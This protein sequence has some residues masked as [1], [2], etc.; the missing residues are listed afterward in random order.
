MI[1]AVL[2]AAL[3]APQIREIE[4]SVRRSM[5]ERQIP[6]VVIRVD[7]GGKNVYSKA[8]GYRDVADRVPANVE[9]R[10]QYGSITKQF[11]AAAIL[12]LQQEGKL[13]ID[14]RIGKWLPAFAT[15]PVTIRELLVHTGGIADY[16]S[17]A[18]YLKGDFTN[19]FVDYGPLLAW[20]ASQPLDFPPGSKAQY[21]NAG[22][23]VLA[24]IV[25]KASGKKYFDFLSE[26][27]L[28][29]LGMTSV[30]P[31]TFFHIEPDTAR[32]YMFA[33]P[34]FEAIG[35]KSGGGLI[36][37]IPWN[38]EQ[39]DGAGFLVGDAADL[40]KWDNALLQHRVLT[41]GAEKLFYE[42]GR[43]N[44]GKPA[45]TGPENPAHRPGAYCYGGLAHF[46]NAGTSAYGANGGTPGFLA[47]TATIPSRQMAVTIL[48][49]HGADIDNGKLTG[50]ILK[51]LL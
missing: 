47:F 26:H 13:S 41:A 2:A 18:W 35:L 20:S 3:T 4:S 6:S 22:Y 44:N 32:G 33:A 9:T 29:P 7:V 45:F 49:N 25:E 10:Y 51:T 16:S 23:V 34:E 40:Q 14:D 43:L 15:F 12:A 19:P 36:P 38:L 21:D 46:E 1:A 17:Q 42:E 28:K 39:A 48:T 37:A 24:R 31:Q 50:P 5:T 30:A 27:F 8:F 11:T